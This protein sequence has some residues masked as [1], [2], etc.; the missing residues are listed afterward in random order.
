MASPREEAAAGL[1][2]DLCRLRLR[3]CPEEEHF[4]GR[5]VHAA[6]ARIPHRAFRYGFL[7]GQGLQGR[8]CY[9]EETPVENFQGPWLLVVLV[10]WAPAGKGSP[11]RDSED[12]PP[13]TARLVT[14]NQETG[15]VLVQGVTRREREPPLRPPDLGPGEREVGRAYSG[16]LGFNLGILVLK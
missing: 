2:G 14:Q 9:T 7:E 1:R 3:S 12:D 5:G 6:G 4:Q 16:D 8:I 11:R 13:A 15:A 10:Y